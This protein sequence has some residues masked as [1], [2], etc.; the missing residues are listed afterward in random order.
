MV[1]ELIL[2]LFQNH[3]RYHK[4]A[5]GG[6]YIVISC[7]WASVRSEIWISAV[8]FCGR[9]YKFGSINANKFRKSLLNSFF[10]LLNFYY[11]TVSFQKRKGKVKERPNKISIQFRPM[12]SIFAAVKQEPP[13]QQLE[14]T[15][16]PLTTASLLASMYPPPTPTGTLKLLP[17]LSAESRLTTM[18]PSAIS[19]KRSTE[20]KVKKIS[21]RNEITNKSTQF[22][23]GGILTSIKKEAKAKGLNLNSNLLLYKMREECQLAASV[24]HY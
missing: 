7:F 20:P 12:P 14:S 13:T 15:L 1:V 9:K 8:G 17:K 24:K 23:M 18:I 3:H 4:I 11:F 10:L 5:Y 22:S 19:S 21:S 2:N 16:T 6:F